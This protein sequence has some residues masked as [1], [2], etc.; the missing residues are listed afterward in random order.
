M[1]SSSK[2]AGLLTGFILG[3]LITLAFF[4]LGYL[5]NLSIVFGVIASICGYCLGSWWQIDQLPST[6]EKSPL[7]PLQRSVTQI[8]VKTKLIQPDTSKTS[9]R[10][11]T[12]AFSLLEWILRQHKTPGPRR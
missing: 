8:L 7:E 9:S 5:L 1:A 6:P 11:P 10:R 2:T 3:L 4:G 12:R